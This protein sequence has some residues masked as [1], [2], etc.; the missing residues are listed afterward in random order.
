M[1][2]DANNERTASAYAA[3]RRASVAIERAMS[4]GVSAAL[5]NA[6]QRYQVPSGEVL[7]APVGVTESR[8]GAQILHEKDVQEVAIMA[9][10]DEFFKANDL[11][12]ELR[13]Y[14]LENAMPTLML[15]LTK[16]LQDVD[17]RGMIDEDNSIDMIQEA[18]A[19]CVPKNMKVQVS[20]KNALDPEIDKP[21]EAPFDPIIWTAQFLYRNNPRYVNAADVS[22]APYFQQLRTVSQQTKAKLFE[23]QLTQRAHQ[24]AE[25]MARKREKERL[26][27]ARTQQMEEM[28]SLFDQLLST[29]FKKW[30]GKLW[31]IVNGSITKTEMLDAYEAILDSHAIQANDNMIA[32][33]TDLIKYLSMPTEVA[34]FLRIELQKRLQAP[35]ETESNSDDA[36]ESGSNTPQKHETGLVAQTSAVSLNNRTSA[37]Q[38]ANTNRDFFCLNA[39]YLMAEKWDIT[40][41]VEGMLILTD[42][43]NWTIDDLSTFLMALAGY[44][45][46]LG[47]NLLTQFNEIYFAPAFRPPT[48]ITLSPKDEWRHKLAKILVEFDAKLCEPLKSSLLDY[49]RGNVTL[50]QLGI[51]STPPSSKDNSHHTS[52]GGRESISN[53][54]GSVSNARG[55]VS[56]A[57]GS[58][59]KE[60]ASWSL[61]VAEAEDGFKKFMMVMVGLYGLSPASTLF[62]YL[63]KKCAEETERERA[64]TAAAA[65][66]AAEIH[67]SPLEL[68]ARVQQIMSLYILDENNAIVTA[69]GLN[70]AI[71]AVVGNASISAKLTP[72]LHSI[73]Q[74]LKHKGIKRELENIKVQPETFVSRILDHLQVSQEEFDQLVKVLGAV[75]DRIMSDSSSAANETALEKLDKDITAPVKQVPG[76]INRAEIQAQAMEELKAMSLRNDMAIA[77]YSQEG[78]KILSRVVETIHPEH[79]V[80]SRLMFAESG[81]VKAD[82]SGDSE[83]LVVERFLRVI[84]CS[85]DCKDAL[86]GAM[87][88]TGEQGFE[89]KTMALGKPFTENEGHTD[90]IF[91]IKLHEGRVVKYLGLPLISSVKKPVGVLGM[92][93]VGPEDGGYAQAD[94][95]FLAN[96]TTKII[97]T[98]ERI[99]SR[100]KLVQITQASV[101]F[102]REK[103]GDTADIR[104]YLNLPAPNPQTSHEEI[105]RLLERPYSS[106]VK[107]PRV[108]SARSREAAQNPDPPE[109]LNAKAFARYMAGA[110]GHSNLEKVHEDSPE[111]GLVLQAVKEHEMINSAPNEQGSIHTYIPIMD[112]DKKVFCVVEVSKANNGKGEVSDEDLAEIK[113]I[114][115]ILSTCGSIAKKEKIGDESVVQHL[116]G[117]SIDE[118]SRRALLFPKMMLVAARQYL[119]K[120][121]NKAISELKS[122]KKPPTAV[123]KVLK[124]VLYMFGKKPKEVQT[125]S[126][127]VKF[128]NLDLLKAMVSYDPTALQKKIRF[129]RCNRVL[130]SL[131]KT[132]IKKKTSIPTLVMYD[133]LIVSLDLRRRAVEAR[134]RHPLVFTESTSSE[135]DDASEAVG[136]IDEEAE[137]AAD[138]AEVDEEGDG[139]EKSE[140]MTKE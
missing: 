127:V 7:G 77:E 38:P 61:G 83:Q 31:R 32:K 70:S 43:G 87:Y 95:D 91:P 28:R 78:S 52:I 24:R 97:D 99:D 88:G 33:V 79:R 113:R 80:S 71:D 112:D 124:A 92:T 120:L 47:E 41:F 138:V 29:V 59:S 139:V 45:D 49:C 89:G 60:V 123:L 11:S 105:Y 9:L 14:L 51:P 16:L 106:I 93:L 48:S 21:K 125:W 73:L 69:D 2:D 121:D 15:A 34:E 85:T 12:L 10:A 1:D 81:V 26:M 72:A 134:K 94:I 126:D 25:A 84:A 130:H 119:S 19:E 63:R 128:V 13:T 64:E 96:A 129:K 98:I 118:E 42:N 76:V 108:A 116:E 100:E 27:K 36:P 46:S 4:A 109:V 122:Y 55:S 136:E 111:S 131:S 101:Q 86:L 132:D 5:S 20:S 6:K 133:W 75:F 103:I 114:S 23:F 90:P 39:E 115:T 62:Q 58:V 54:R 8:Q 18:D 56:N 135:M 30:T 107:D 102:M 110:S 53:T 67:L 104:V 57:R 50:S 74:N 68:Q 37:S 117:E 66:A 40:T 137:N 65:T 35:Q 44:I 22:N 140:E 3:S 82:A 17:R